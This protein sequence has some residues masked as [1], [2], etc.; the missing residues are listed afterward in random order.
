MKNYLSEKMPSEIGAAI[1]NVRFFKHGFGEETEH[2]PRL[3][4]LV[5]EGNDASRFF[6]T[7]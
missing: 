4:G 2:R 6:Q 5:V 3:L 1:L 7:P